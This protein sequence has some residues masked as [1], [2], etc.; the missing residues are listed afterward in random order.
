[1]VKGCWVCLMN[2]ML[3]DQR[4]VAATIASPSGNGGQ[5]LDAALILADGGP[6]GYADPAFDAH[7]LP[8]GQW[9]TAVWEDWLP[10]TS[11]QKSVSTAA[12]NIERKPRTS[13][14]YVMV[15]GRRSLR[16]AED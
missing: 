5:D 10:R 3:R 8:I 15:Q 1:M 4:R 6:K 11:L 13:G 12:T 16:L 9:A 7:V 2:A 14:R